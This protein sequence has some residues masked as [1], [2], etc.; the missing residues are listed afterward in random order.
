MTI[1]LG[2]MSLAAAVVLA[3]SLGTSRAHAASYLG[4]PNTAVA[5][6]GLV[7]A[8]CAPG[9]TVGY[10]QF[11]LRRGT[12]E[13][14]EGGVLISASV[15]AKRIAG[16]EDPRI[17]V[18]RP[19]ADGASLTVVDSAPV[20]VT[21]PTG[22]VVNVDDLHLQMLEGDSIGFLFRTGEV[23]LGMKARPK[24]DG[25][26]QSFTQPCGPCGM[27]GGTGVELLFNGVVEPDI[28][29][30]GLGDETQDPDG[31]GLGFDWEDQ[32]F[33]DYD[34][35]DQLDPDFST[36]E[37]ASRARRRPLAILDVD[38]LRG[39]R[40]SLLLSVPKAGR[41]S[42]SVTLPASARTGAG[43]FLTTL[44]GDMRVKRP[45]RVRLRLDATP[46]GERVLQRRKSVRTKIVVALFPRNHGSLELRMRS[47]RL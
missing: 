10:R 29:D 12:V 7:C 43:P 31:G 9:M 34:A 30:D 16:T 46:A 28:D 33:E 20:P 13:A 38:R 21:S 41:V 45:G 35:G 15:W 11:A 2:L 32:W 14:P 44:T 3:L 19:A 24:P 18:L 8:S 1:R 4:S 39:G 26:V 42:A 40:A 22:S 27:D 47:A 36:D 37:P 5:P 17:A 25:A 6:A 23:D